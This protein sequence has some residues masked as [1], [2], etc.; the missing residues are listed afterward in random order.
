MTAQRLDTNLHR[1]DF[2]LAHAVGDLELLFLDGDVEDLVAISGDRRLDVGLDVRHLD[3]FGKE[4]SSGENTTSSPVS[5]SRSSLFKL[6]SRQAGPG[7]EGGSRL[8]SHVASPKGPG[9][10]NSGIGGHVSARIP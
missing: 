6:G 3:V 5:C 9:T 8:Q 7:G 4:M 1:P 10:G 2:A